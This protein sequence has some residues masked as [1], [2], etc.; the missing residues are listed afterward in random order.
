MRKP[1]KSQIKRY[2]FVALVAASVAIH[3]HDAKAKN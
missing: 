3:I 1:T 2:A